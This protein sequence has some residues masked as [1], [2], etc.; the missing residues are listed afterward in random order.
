MDL[1]LSIKKIYYNNYIY[2]ASAI[3]P[4]CKK[5]D[6]RKHDH[7]ACIIIK[8]IHVHTYSNYY[9]ILYKY[10]VNAN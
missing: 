9:T 3:T 8:H 4:A 10:Y 1:G 7:D 5:V 6:D 2:E